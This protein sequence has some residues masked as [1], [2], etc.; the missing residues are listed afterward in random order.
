M[1]ERTQHS[2]EMNNLLDTADSSQ[3]PSGTKASSL[4][5]QGGATAALAA[6]P[7]V[8]WE[9]MVCGAIS[10]SVAQTIMHP[11]NTM[12]TMLQSRMETD[13]FGKLM[14]PSNF[15][16]LTI[17][18]G[19]NFVLSLPHGAVN[20][21]VLE[22]VRSK[23]TQLLPA[24]AGG[25]L[26]PGLDFV[27]SCLSTVCC[28]VVSTPQMMIIDNIMAGNYPNLPAAA[29]GLYQQRGIAGFYAGW[30]PGLAGKIPSYVSNDKLLFVFSMKYST[31]FS[32][33]TKGLNMDILPELKEIHS[34]TFKRPAKDVENSIMGCVASATTVC[35]MIPLDTIKTRLVTQITA[36]SNAD[37]YKGILDCAFRVYR[38]EG[39]G[40]FYR[41]LSPRLL[42]VV[43]MIGIQFGVY[44][45]T[46][47]MM[48]ERDISKA[49]EKR[50]LKF[51]KTPEE[52]QIEAEEIFEEDCFETAVGSSEPFPSHKFRLGKIVKKNKMIH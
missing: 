7:L 34:S 49:E 35:I 3:T 39:M 33:S 28:S 1:I 15:H 21:A 8:F 14:S 41:G 6:R 25:R 37:A 4:K 20:F 26:G 9:N 23:L 46:K 48:R 10:R 27:S 22:F 13:S 51:K 31:R 45:F 2:D 19:A 47:K 16:R 11:A 36:P 18:A 52:S 42:S 24:E 32:P 17:G 5:L 30:F 43:P 38:E 50:L 44:E 40:A 29:R 12:K